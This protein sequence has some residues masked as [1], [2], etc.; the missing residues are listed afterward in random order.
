[1]IRITAL[2][3]CLQPRLTKK[4]RSAALCLVLMAIGSLGVLEAKT[5]RANLL[6]IINNDPTILNNAVLGYSRAADGSLTDLPGS[7]F[8]TGG[9]G[10]RNTNERIGPDDSDGELIIS[11]DHRFMFATNTGS[12]DISVFQIRLDGSL[13]L[14]PGS[15]FPSGGIAPVSLALANGFLYVVNRGDGILPTQV[16][17][18]YVKGTRGATNYSV[19]NVNLDGSLTLLPNLKVD[20]PDGSSPSQVVVTPDGQFMFGDTFLSPSQDAPFAGIFPFAHSLLASFTLDEDDGSTEVQPAVGI[21]NGAPFVVSG[22]FRPFLLGMRPHPSQNILYVQ[23]VT[24]GALVVFNW[25][26]SGTLTFHGAVGANG[27]GGQ[28]WTAIDPAAKFLYT[29]A[30]GP[31]A[32]SVFSLADPLNP[33]FVQNFTLGG[34]KGNLPAGTPEPETFTTAPFNLSVEPGGKFLY[35]VNHTTCTNVNIDAT[36]CPAGNAIHI[37][38]INTDGTLAETPASPLIFPATMVPNETHPKG[39]VVL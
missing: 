15:P 16:A 12:N 4:R 13:R 6:Y 11:P 24:A 25:D 17:P 20:V 29:S 27:A 37:M 19:M 35:V 22:V 36:N 8:Y 32:I 9:T 38:K 28:C 23:A 18:A 39:I 1:M 31:D 21:P 5:G 3:P 26:T 34:P 2:P 33:T 7:P 10:Y 30:I 14:V